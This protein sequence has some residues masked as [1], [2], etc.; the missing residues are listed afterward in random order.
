MKIP[1]FTAE[2]SLHTVAKTY[3]SVATQAHATAQTV[4]VPQCCE[5]ICWTYHGVQRCHLA[6]YPGLCQ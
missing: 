6:C 5:E 4:V 3:A 1:G 2:A